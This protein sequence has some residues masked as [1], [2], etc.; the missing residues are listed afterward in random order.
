MTE[1]ELKH[2]KFV[3]KIVCGTLIAA[4]GGIGMYLDVS[5]SFGFA[6]FGAVIVAA[7]VQDDE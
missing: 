3:I 2:R 4:M 5:F 6:F 7:S 1:E